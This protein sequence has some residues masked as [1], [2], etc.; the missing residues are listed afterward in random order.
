MSSPRISTRLIAA[1]G[2]LAGLLL[3][4][5]AS[6]A[7]AHDE[8]LGTDPAEGAVLDEAPEAITLTFSGVLLDGDGATEIVVTDAAGTDLTAGE[9]V[10]DGVRATQP[11]DG[12]ASG[13]IE[14]AWRVVSSDGHPISGEF[15]FAVGEASSPTSESPAP[16]GPASPGGAGGELLP[17]WIGVGAIVVVGAVVTVL[18]TRRR[19]SHED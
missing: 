5:S 11:L 15:S 4:G 6:P 3:A 19:P 12:A 1:L 9:P 18:L 14:V 2:V 8:L 17:V 10:L 16:G 13:T 7:L